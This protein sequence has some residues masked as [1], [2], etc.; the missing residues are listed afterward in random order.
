MPGQIALFAATKRGCLFLKKLKRLVPDYHITVFSFR[1]E[2]WEPPFFEEIRELTAEAGGSFFEAKHVGD[3]QFQ[4]FWQNQ[5]VEL[6]FCVSW[7][8]MVPSLVYQKATKGTYVFHDSMLPRYRGFSPTVWAVINGEQQT[9]VTLFEMADEVDAGDI[10]DQ[11]EVSIGTDETIQPVIDRVTQTYLALLERNLFPLLGGTAR[12]TPQ[13]HAHAT[14]VCK[15]LPEDNRIDWTAPARSSY[16]LIRAVTAPY[17]GAYTTLNDRTLRVWSAKL[18]DSVSRYEGV[19]PGRVVRFQ[20]GE[21][22]TVLTGKGALLLQEV[23]FDGEE[24][25]CASRILNRLSC[26]LR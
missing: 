1:E 4:E 15:R 24:R 20:Q 10:I 8:Y 7:R 17:P 26:T 23:Q 21:G 14:F 11:E 12:K 3:Q 9:G 5:K 13:D 25:V 22:A 16:N 2:P 6:I 19:I 18:L